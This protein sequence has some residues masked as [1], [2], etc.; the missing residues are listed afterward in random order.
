MTFGLDVWGIKKLF[1]VLHRYEAS[2]QRLSYS[3]LK[4]PDMKTDKMKQLTVSAEV[5]C[6][7]QLF[8]LDTP[9]EKAWPTLKRLI[10]ESVPVFYPSIATIDAS[11]LSKQT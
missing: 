8:S 10:K 5:I 11:D 9:L 7:S 3:N 6:R 4:S 1:S 2:L